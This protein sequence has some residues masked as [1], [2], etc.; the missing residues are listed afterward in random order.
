MDK[1]Y[2]SI[3]AVVIAE[4]ATVDLAT[5][6]DLLGSERFDQHQR[7]PRARSSFTQVATS[8]GEIVGWALIA[9]KR[10]G[11]GSATI[12]AG[13]IEIG[14]RE[15][16]PNVATNLL[17]TSLRVLGENGLPLALLH[18]S[19]SEFEP[20]GFA[21][22][23]FQ[24]ETVLQHAKGHKQVLQPLG[25]DDLDSVAALYQATYAA[26]PIHEVRAVPDWR[27]IFGKA[28]LLGLNDSRGRLHAYVYQQGETVAEAAAADGSAVRAL[29]EALPT[30][31]LALS[32]AHPVTRTA[33]QLGATTTVAAH[34]EDVQALAGIVD[35]PTMLEQLVPAFEQRLV[36]SRYHG[37]SGNIRIEIE[38]E[39]VTL[40]FSEGRAEVIDGSR[41]ADLRLRRVTLSALVQCCLGYRSISDLRATNELDFDDS[42]LGL[43]EILFPAL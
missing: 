18:G 28:S 12:E 30:A 3:Q 24:V 16:S 25:M 23:Q 11:M 43:F 26:L 13:L 27:A 7:R 21:P 34:S 5:L 29:L 36:H 9:H 35:L 22:Y 38:T 40:A 15:H 41:P 39:R 31:K 42:A 10:I 20:F 33:L 19:R 1:A 14:V 32:L 2:D 6:N 37:W 4:A 8:G 17:G